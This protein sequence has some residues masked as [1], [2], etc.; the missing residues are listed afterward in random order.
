MGRRSGKKKS[1][2]SNL[3]DDV[4]R[5]PKGWYCEFPVRPGGPE[6]AACRGIRRGPRPVRHE[7]VKA[8]RLRGLVGRRKAFDDE[9]RRVR[10]DRHSGVRRSRRLR[11]LRARNGRPMASLRRRPRPPAARQD[12]D[13]ASSDR[14][15]ASA[16]PTASSNRPR[17]DCGHGNAGE[18][19]RFPSR[20]SK[21]RPGPGLQHRFGPG[22]SSTARS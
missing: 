17:A 18:A 16:R 19:R 22:P 13:S 7:C 11:R 2:R 12:R 4:P 15:R 8:L 10:V 14:I 3:V 1:A 20:P 21:H 5:R 6:N 9:A